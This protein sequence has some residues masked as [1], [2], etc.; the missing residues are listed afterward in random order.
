MRKGS[1]FILIVKISPEGI[2]NFTGYFTYIMTSQ[3]I[4]FDL[5]MLGMQIGFLFGDSQI[6]LIEMKKRLELDV[7]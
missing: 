5:Y 3:T 7:G 2:Q 4:S 1:L 6:L